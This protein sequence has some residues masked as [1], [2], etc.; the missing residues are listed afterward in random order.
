[1]QLAAVKA[2]SAEENFSSQGRTLTS[3]LRCG[4]RD[5]VHPE[6]TA[7]KMMTEARRSVRAPAPVPR[8]SAAVSLSE[9]MRT[10]ASVSSRDGS[11]CPR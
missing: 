5:P 6:S 8:S 4:V 2:P 9:A 10:H 3:A 11:H 7:P 1:M